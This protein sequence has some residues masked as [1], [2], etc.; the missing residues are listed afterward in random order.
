M[1]Q[2]MASKP[3]TANVVGWVKYAMAWD[4]IG[5]LR[6]LRAQQNPFV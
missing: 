4:G 2:P 6:A 5:D 3:A 1:N